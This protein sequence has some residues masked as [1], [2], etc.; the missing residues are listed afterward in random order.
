MD[1][2]A[3]EHMNED[4][5]DALKVI[6]EVLG[7]APE[8]EWRAV[9]VDPLGI[10]MVLATG[11]GA[12]L[13]AGEIAARVEYDTPVGESHALRMALVTLTKRARAAASAGTSSGG[14]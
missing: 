11:G 12:P 5:L 8:G 10:D 7:E 2:G 1:A 9:G 4:H 3:C 13:R 14:G 6:A